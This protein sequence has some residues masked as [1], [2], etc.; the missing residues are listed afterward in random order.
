[1]TFPLVALYLN[2]EW[3]QASKAIKICLSKFLCQKSWV[4]V[5]GSMSISI[6]IYII[7]SWGFTVNHHK[8]KYRLNTNIMVHMFVNIP[9]KLGY[10]IGW[11]SD[12]SMLN[13]SIV[14]WGP[15]FVIFFSHHPCYAMAR[16]FCQWALKGN[17]PR[18]AALA[19]FYAHDGPNFYMFQNDLHLYKQEK[20]ARCRVPFSWWRW[21]LARPQLSKDIKIFTITF[22]CI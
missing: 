21:V 18:I 4:Y 11:F 20:I 22:I 7:L 5:Y 3:F 9:W 13:K 6:C 19:T 2:L 12:R 17:A 16:W 1:M 8:S 15:E 10:V 14:M